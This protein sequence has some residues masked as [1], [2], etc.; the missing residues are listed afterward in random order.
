MRRVLAGGDC[1]PAGKFAA[2]RQPVRVPGHQHHNSQHA[3]AAEGLRV[4]LQ[5]QLHVLMH[6]FLLNRLHQPA[7]RQHAG[8]A[9][10]VAGSGQQG[11]RAAGV[12]G[13]GQQ[14]SRCGRQRA[15]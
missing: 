14:G 8:R 9:A 10:G 2:Q 1:Q 12:A 6:I 5:R 4:V 15:Q 7:L 3:H 13:S 11:S